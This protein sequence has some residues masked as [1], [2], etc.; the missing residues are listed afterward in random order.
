MRVRRR[1]GS[2]GAQRHGLIGSAGMPARMPDEPI[3]FPR[4]AEYDALILARV[5]R[6]VLFQPFLSSRAYSYHLCNRPLV[7]LKRTPVRSAE[8]GV[9]SSAAAVRGCMKRIGV[10]IRCRPHYNVCEWSAIELSE[11]GL[12]KHE[13]DD[14]EPRTTCQLVR[15]SHP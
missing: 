7:I 8:L 13:P 2:S 6:C 15:P 9:A 3:T 14:P 10:A 11:K 5:Q 12:W 4:R 1:R